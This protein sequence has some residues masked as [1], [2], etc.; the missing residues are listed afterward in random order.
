MKQSKTALSESQRVSTRSSGLHTPCVRT[1]EEAVDGFMKIK[2]Q[3]EGVRKQ[4]GHHCGTL[5]LVPRI[6]TQPVSS[7]DQNPECQQK[8]KLKLREGKHLS[9]V[10]QPKTI[11]GLSDPKAQSFFPLQ[12]CLTLLRTVPSQ[13]RGIDS[14]GISRHEVVPYQKHPE[15]LLMAI[16]F[17]SYTQYTLPSRL[18][19]H[20]LAS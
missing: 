5:L 4:A 7:L 20:F 11:L 3:K 15:T 14:A 8:N 17:S 13:E 19:I 9:Q 12:C 6:L 1:L 2:Y 18:P 16:C 10:A